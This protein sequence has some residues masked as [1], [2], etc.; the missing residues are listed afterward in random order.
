MGRIGRLDGRRRAEDGR[1]GGVFRDPGK[2]ERRHL[3]EIN[4]EGV[5]K[6][7]L[8][9]LPGT[10]IQGTVALGGY[11]VGVRPGRGERKD[12]GFEDAVDAGPYPRFLQS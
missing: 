6:G 10:S 11:G 7:A 2:V 5:G 4:F 9:G 8:L 12:G 1:L 3:P